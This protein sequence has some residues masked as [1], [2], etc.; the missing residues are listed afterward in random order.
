MD[1]S[2]QDARFRLAVSAIDAGDVVRL[3]EI[4]ADTPAL[5]CQRLDSPG[6]WLRDKVGTALD[7]FFQRP[8]LL[9]FVAEDPVRHGRLPGNI[10]E[11][12]RIII[13]AA[14]GRCPGTV[15]EQVD[16]ALRLVAFSW[17]A[18]DSNVQLGLIDVL[19][20]AGASPEGAPEDA[21]VN[22]NTEAAA[23]L[24]GSGAPLTL[25][26]ALCLERWDDVPALAASSTPR[27]K[28]F[29]MTLAALRGKAEALRRLIAM[30]VDLNAVSQDLY[31]HATPLH[32]AVGSGSLDAV[33]VLVEAGARLDATDTVYQGTPL[34]WAEHSAGKPHFDAIAAF[35]REIDRGLSAARKP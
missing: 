14:Q 16:Y 4:L 7:D 19:L 6:A 30:G 5:A 21:L 31:A 25:A 23:H 20:E 29:A 28:Q 18:R 13:A 11:I 3:K 12:A 32:H 34:G 2:S 22:N 26:T 17:I 10:G 33:K 35:L 27:Q 8:Y 24:V 1:A 9:W 15:Q